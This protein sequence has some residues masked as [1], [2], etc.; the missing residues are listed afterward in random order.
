ML[1]PVETP[2]IVMYTHMVTCGKGKGGSRNKPHPAGHKAGQEVEPSNC[3]AQGST[4]EYWTENPSVTMTETT[5]YKGI[6]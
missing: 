1:T 2:L 4:P 5:E 3:P 6:S